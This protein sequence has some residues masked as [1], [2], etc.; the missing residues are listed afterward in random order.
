MVAECPESHTYRTVILWY[1]STPEY[2]FSGDH[3]L[4]DPT[5]S[6]SLQSLGRAVGT[7][8]RGSRRG[9]KKGRDSSTRLSRRKCGGHCSSRH[10]VTVV[11]RST[12]ETVEWCSVGPP[13]GLI[14]DHGGPKEY[15][16]SA[17]D[18]YNR[19]SL[20]G[21]MEPMGAR[22]ALSVYPSSVNATERQ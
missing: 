18:R 13:A 20:A 10:A 7:Y 16:Y 6:G 9:S 11:I 21:E 12:E 5:I 8:R 14:R 1:G 15:R 22:K 3:T 17:A 4:G 2:R 19:G